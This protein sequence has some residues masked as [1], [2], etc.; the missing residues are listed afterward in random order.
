MPKMPDI[1]IDVLN[2]A[3]SRSWYK[4]LPKPYEHPALHY[5]CIS[6]N[7]L[8]WCFTN[9]ENDFPIE[10]N[11]EL[12]SV[13]STKLKEFEDLKEPGNY[14]N[15]YDQLYKFQVQCTRFWNEK[16]PEE[17]IETPHE[18]ADFDEKKKYMKKIIGKKYNMRI[19]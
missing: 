9:A 8:N 17:S 15:Q 5:P 14:E 3:E 12:S 6:E 13:G 1:N 18:L 4:H 10:V 7:G 19:L 11:S 16:Y 2:H